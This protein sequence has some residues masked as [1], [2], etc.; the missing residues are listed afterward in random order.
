MQGARLQDTQRLP[1]C[2][3]AG[4][5]RG[6]KALCLSYHQSPARMGPLAHRGRATRSVTAILGR[7]QDAADLLDQQV[8]AALDLQR[9]IA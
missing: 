8:Q 6:R 1:V 3:P 5:F 2:L 7:N 9:T 4:A